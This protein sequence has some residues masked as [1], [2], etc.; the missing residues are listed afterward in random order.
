MIQGA[1]DR[2]DPPGESAED[3]R[4]FTDGYR[5]VV[6]DGV[7]HFPAREAPV[8]VAE[9]IVAHLRIGERGA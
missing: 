4:Y 7:G 9:E 2:C 8:R 1:E 3:Q 6:L 5:R